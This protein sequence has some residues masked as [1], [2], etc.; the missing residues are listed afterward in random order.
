MVEVE[1]EDAMNIKHGDLIYLDVQE[2]Q[3]PAQRYRV[4]SF[5]DYDDVQEIPRFHIEVTEEF[6]K[7]NLD[8]STLPTASGGYSVLLNTGII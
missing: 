8:S 2:G 1:L 3:V 7:L 4:L 5:F 6:N